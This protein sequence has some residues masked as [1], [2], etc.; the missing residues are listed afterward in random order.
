MLIS[1]SYV[2]HTNWKIKPIYMLKGLGQ[3]RDF[4]SDSV[5][6]Q[7]NLQSTSNHH[8]KWFHTHPMSQNQKIQDIR[9]YTPFGQTKDFGVFVQ[10]EIQSNSIQIN[11]N[12]I[13]SNSSNESKI[14]KSKIPKIQLYSANM[15]YLG[16]IIP[17]GF[18]SN[19]SNQNAIKHVISIL[20]QTIYSNHAQI[21]FTQI[22][23]P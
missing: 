16:K 17:N 22:L 11:V 14:K 19:W 9:A 21:T 8:P 23:N 5:S 2:K 15:S 20:K 6:I 18:S 3:K 4:V 12:L 10:F 7:S 13:D 1:L